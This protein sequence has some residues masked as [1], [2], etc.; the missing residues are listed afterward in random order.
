[1]LFVPITIKFTTELFQMIFWCRAKGILTTLRR[2]IALLETLLKDI[3]AKPKLT[4][5]L[6]IW[7]NS[8]FIS[9][10]SI[11]LYLFSNANIEELK[12]KEK[13]GKANNLIMQDRMLMT[14]EYIREYRKKSTEIYKNHRGDRER[15]NCFTFS[16]SKSSC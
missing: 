2:K 11:T 13:G 9:I 3:I 8:L 10:S 4:Q 15:A 14:L 6:L 7:L 5:R 12:K 1:M 16:I